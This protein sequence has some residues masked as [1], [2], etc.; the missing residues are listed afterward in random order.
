M[1]SSFFYK[2]YAGLWCAVQPILCRNKRLADGWIERCVPKNWLGEWGEERADL[3]IQA[4]SGGEALLALELLSQ[5][6]DGERVR[7][8]I[9]TWTRQGRDV[10]EKGVLEWKTEKPWLDVLVRFAPLDEPSIARRAVDLARPKLLLLLETELW[11][12]LMGACAEAGVPVHVFNGRMA[13][14]SF[15]WYKVIRKSLRRL[16]LACVYAISREDAE[17][18]ALI[19]GEDK[20]KL[21]PT[22]QTSLVTPV[23]EFL[24]PERACDLRIFTMPNIKFDRAARAA[25]VSAGAPLATPHTIRLAHLL[26]PSKT[27]T[28]EVGPIILLASVR[29]QEETLLA[30]QLHAIFREIP[31]ALVI[32]APRHMHRV[33]A[34]SDRLYDIGLSPLLASTL[35]DAKPPKCAVPLTFAPCACPAIFDDP[36]EDSPQNVLRR[37]LGGRTIIWDRFGDLT[38]LYALADAVFVGGSFGRGGQNFL[39]ALAAGVVPCVGPSLEN[40]RWALGNDTPPSLIDA[41][42]LCVCPRPRKVG[43]TLIAKAKE[44]IPASPRLDSPQRRDTRERFRQWLAPRAGA[45]AVAS[46]ITLKT[47]RA[48]DKTTN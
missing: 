43:T 29:T 13:K 12:G 47:L 48:L 26:A 46:S 10:L 34:W 32:V 19:F 41:G 15:E 24:G 6:D 28:R 39:E 27:C 2:V 45:S 20:A 38:S 3:W 35:V 42:L 5:M 7:V 37:G 33:P 22:P 40:F 16:P 21:A 8:L 23:A 1:L 18:F 17:R 30:P 4:A 11:P 9:T 36:T 25:T 31:N 44:R 14:A